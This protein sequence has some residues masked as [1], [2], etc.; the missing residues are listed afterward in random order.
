MMNRLH[1]IAC[2]GIGWTVSLV[3][4]LGIV[5][6]NH[7]AQPFAFASPEWWAGV[8]ALPIGALFLIAAGLA[9]DMQE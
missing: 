7:S 3:G 1:R 6:N 2:L 8:S 5:V 9:K 4:V